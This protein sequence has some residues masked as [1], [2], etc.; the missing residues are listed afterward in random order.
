MAIFTNQ[1]MLSYNGRSI[2]S[3]VTTGEILEV[4]AVY[5]TAVSAGYEPGGRVTYA[6]SLVNSGDIAVSGF[7]VS[8][9]LGGYTFDGD[10][11]YP[12]S[13][14]EGSLVC[15][16]NGVRETVPAVTAGP[17]MT[18]SGIDL[19]AGGSAVL[20]YEAQATAYAPLGIDAEISNT[21]TAAGT[22][23][24]A[25]L[26]ATAAVSADMAPRLSITKSV[27]PDTVVGN[28]ELT[29][30]FLIQN[31]GDEAGADAG[32]AIT[33]TFDPVLEN[34]MVLLNGTPMSST[35]YTYDG[36]TGVFA[37]DSGAIIVPAAVFAQNS[38]G[39]WMTTPGVAELTVSGTI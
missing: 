9:D 15:L 25:P 5:K 23:I 6:V 20:I 26:T 30:T 13:Y 18:V 27:S 19:P 33:D 12:L 22:G 10:T 8:D 39:T 36:S 31:T 24:A 38:D 1:A 7:T 14:V 32:V 34:L 3:N 29:Y 17:P 21:V 4:V 37:T 11:L 16:V 35:G 28:S 2:H